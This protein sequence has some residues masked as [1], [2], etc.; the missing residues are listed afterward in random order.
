VGSAETRLTHC[1][2]P[3]LIVLNPVL[4]PRSSP[5]ALHVKRR[6]RPLLAKVGNYG[7]ETADQI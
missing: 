4:F 6:E 1:S 2:L 3:R 5:E 7:R